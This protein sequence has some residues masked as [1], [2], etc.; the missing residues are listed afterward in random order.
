MPVRDDKRK[1]KRYEMELPVTLRTEGRFVPAAT[2][3]ISQ[4]GMC[5]L[6]DYQEKIH[7]GEAEVVLDLSRDQRDVS[8][9]GRILRFEKG[10]G[11]RVAVEFLP[12]TQ[13]QKALGHFLKSK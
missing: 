1:H 4:G 2:I 6:T 5:L 3:N 12:D 8:V 9:R 10:I 7:T 13:G 11:Q